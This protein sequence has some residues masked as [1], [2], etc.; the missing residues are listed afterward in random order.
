MSSD[1]ISDLKPKSSGERLSYVTEAE[2][3]Q[4]NPTQGV[5]YCDKLDK[6]LDYLKLKTL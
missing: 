3:K 6:N 1:F 4:R 2:K 5:D